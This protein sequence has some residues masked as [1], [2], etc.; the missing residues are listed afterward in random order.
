MAKVKLRKDFWIKPGSK[1]GNARK[2]GA[3]IW[4]SRINWKGRTFQA[5]FEIKFP[6]GSRALPKGAACGVGK[7]PRKAVAAAARRL[8]SAY[9]EHGG[10]RGRGGAFARYR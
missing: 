6:R 2:I 7:N 4:I 3:E 8:A 5:C 9:V 1:A 10:L